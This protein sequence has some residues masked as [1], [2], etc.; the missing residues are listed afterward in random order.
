MGVAAQVPVGSDGQPELC[1]PP[2]SQ[3]LRDLPLQPQ[4]MGSLVPQQIN[5]WMGH[6][7]EGACC[8][9]KPGGRRG[10]QLLSC[11]VLLETG[12]CLLEIGPCLYVK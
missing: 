10:T 7:A 11:S 8:R 4:A 3:L 2:V 1:A 6:A 9:R 5:V 12:L